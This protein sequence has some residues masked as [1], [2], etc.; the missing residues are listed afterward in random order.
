VNDFVWKSEENAKLLLDG[1]N[2]HWKALTLTT[3]PLAYGARVNIES[4]LRMISTLGPA[5]YM[6]HAAPRTFG[7][8]TIGTASG[9]R[10]WFKSHADSLREE[11]LRKSMERVEGAWNADEGARIAA[12]ADEVERLRGNDEILVRYDEDPVTLTTNKPSGLYFSFNR[13]GF[14]SPYK[15][16]GTKETQM[17]RAPGAKVLDVTDTKFEHPL[18]GEVDGTAGTAALKALLPKGEFDA[19]LKL[20]ERELRAKISQALPGVDVPKGLDELALLELWGAQVA[21]KRGYDAISFKTTSTDP[22][23]LAI[24]LHMRDEYVALNDQAITE[25]PKY[26]PAGVETDPEYAAMKAEH[27]EIKARLDLYRTGGRKGRRAAYGAFGE[28][29][30]KSIQTRAGEIPGAFDTEQGRL[31]RWVISSETSAALLGDSS[32]LSMKSS[33]LTNWGYVPNTDIDNHM[34]SWLHA[35]NAQLMQSQVGKK[36]VELYDELGDKEK[37]ANVLARWATGTP[38]GR[39]LMGELQWTAHNKQEYARRIIG[40]VDHYLPSPALREVAAKEGRVTQ[41]ELE[42]ALPNIEDRPPVHGESI[43]MDTGRGSLLGERIN[44]VYSKILRWA[45]DASEDQLARHPMYAAVYEQE[46]KRRAEFLLADPRIEALTGGDIKR[47][48]QDQA[49]KKARQAI[50]NYMYDVA[51]TSDLSHFMRFVSPFVKAWEDTVRKWG[52]IIAEDPSVL[53]RA[54]LV[55]NAP[56]DMGLVVDE[57]GNPVEQDGIFGYR[58]P[59]TGKLKSTYLVIPSG[60][61]KWIPGAGDSDLKISKQ[62][63]NLVLQGGLQPGFGPLVSYPVGKIQTAAPQL[64][65]VAKL[66]NPYGPPESVWDAVAPSTLKAIYDATDAQS[67]THQQD[68]RRIWAQMLAEYKLDPQKFGGQQPTIEEASKRAG[69]LGRLKIFNRVTQPFP[70]IFQ[71]P[72]QL[73]IDGYRALQERERSEGHPY[74]WADD[75]FV[76]QYG[77]TYFPLVQSESKNNAG[78]GSSAE[79]VDAAKRYKSLISKYGIEAGQAKPSLIRLIVGQEGEGDFNASAHQW[80]ESREI[81]PASGLKYRTYDNPQ[82]AQAQADADLGWLKYRQFMNNLDAMALEQGFQTYADS[83][84]LVQTRKEFIANLQAENESWHVEW[85]Q[86]DSDAFERD[87]KSLGEIATSGKFGPMRTDMVGVQQYLALRQALQQELADY[88]ISEGSQDAKPFKQEFTSAVQQLVSQN[89]QFAEWSYYTFLERDPL[90]EPVEPGQSLQAP[91]D[92]GFGS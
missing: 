10:A 32:K 58:D 57:D 90:L 56:N 71:S 83:D 69:A 54:N 28:A 73:Y 19:A 87:L 63:F 37:A 7:F 59:K 22:R 55:W 31:N 3:R 60:A 36:A 16:P 5:A 46:A 66:V 78:L 68:T 11:E 45:S 6:M 92:W 12:H 35:V 74:G 14:Q 64:N 49:H 70:A 27:A 72:Y 79:A 85:S 29:G 21:K 52:R 76:Q 81:S 61:T 67:R 17:R 91:T 86:R 89:S 18:A 39:K 2:H 50:K 33:Q 65:D 1:F 34:P 48:V 62:A 44:G 9:A 25:V 8:A 80:Q 13:K 82:E 43:A 47:L 38:E 24:D 75:E 84:E 42:A 53:G 15:W 77:D 26:K 20:T 88:G 30:Y 51:A 40:H 4:A 41:K 23:D